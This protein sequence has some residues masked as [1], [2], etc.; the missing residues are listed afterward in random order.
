M[1]IYT[2]IYFAYVYTQVGIEMVAL[3]AKFWDLRKMLITRGKDV[4]HNRA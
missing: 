2:H 4:L 1:Y 3:K